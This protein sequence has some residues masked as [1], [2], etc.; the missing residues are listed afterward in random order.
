MAN[1]RKQEREPDPLTGEA[2]MRAMVA[3]EELVAA[4]N[5]A[6]QRADAGEPGIPWE[7]VKR[8]LNAR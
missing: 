8:E 4:S 2:L 1:T 6:K 3:D 5:A 7:D